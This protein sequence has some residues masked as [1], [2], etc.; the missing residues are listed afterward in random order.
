MSPNSAT[1][2]VLD[3]HFL[4]QEPAIS[5]DARQA[6]P[7]AGEDLLERIGSDLYR[8]A[9]MLLGEG[10]DAV[11]LIEEVI[12]HLDLDSPGAH[13]D[14]RHHARLALSGKAIALLHQ[15]EAASLAAPDEDSIASG[16]VSCIE[17]DDLDAAGLTPIQFEE[18]LTGPDRNRLRD[19][20]LSLSSAL[21]VIFVLRAVAALTSAEVAGLLAEN[22]SP[23]A[24][25]WTPEAVRTTFRQALCSLASQL[26]HAS[27]SR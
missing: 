13:E 2:I 15:R 1:P 3:G 22:A 18:L 4:P 19:W 7:T 17:D 5:V 26:I 14:L 24:E 9:S 21:R 27:A 25:L 8:I 20:L 10:E 12:T 11:A 23:E 6:I 16:P